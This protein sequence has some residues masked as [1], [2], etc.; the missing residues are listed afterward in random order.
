MKKLILATLLAFS[1]SIFAQEK[2]E[3]ETKENKMERKSPEERAEM[4]LKK[5]S[6]ELNLNAK[7]QEQIKQFMIE[8]RAKRQAMMK[9]RM[10]NKEIPKVPTPEERKLRKQKMDD[11]KKAMDEKLKTILTPEQFTKWNAFQE[12]RKDKMKEE[13]EGKE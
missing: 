1:V 8:N 5:L 7:Q 12:A 4:H 13:R 6:T 2:N 3:K 11:G 10:A 9:E